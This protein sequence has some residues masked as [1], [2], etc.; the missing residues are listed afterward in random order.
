[1]A[2]HDPKPPYGESPQKAETKQTIVHAAET[3]AGAN[4]R[5]HR[6]STLREAYRDA[7]RACRR[8]LQRWPRVSG[9]SMTAV[10]VGCVLSTIVLGS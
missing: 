1:M 10:T 2:N 7:S 4:E 8:Q 5:D 3:A 9:G 6:F